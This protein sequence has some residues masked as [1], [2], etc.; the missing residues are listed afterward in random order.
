MRTRRMAF[1]RIKLCD[2]TQTFCH[3]LRVSSG[4]SWG[5]GGYAVRAV[6]SPSSS[7]NKSAFCSFC[8]KLEPE[9]QSCIGKNRLTSKEYDLC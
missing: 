4:G 9:K 3:H 5:V 8:R 7:S 6:K 2:E 1:E